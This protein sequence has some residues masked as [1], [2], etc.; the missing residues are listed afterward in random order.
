MVKRVAFNAAGWALLMLGV[1]GLLLPVLPGVALLIVGLSFLSLEYKW[2]RRWIGP[3]LRRF[4]AAEKKLQV[5][6]ARHMKSISA[7][8]SL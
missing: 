5:F 3:L 4:P 2:A 6:I 8:A 7:N 1:A